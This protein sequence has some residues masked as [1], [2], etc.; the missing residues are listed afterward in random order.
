MG[1]LVKLLIFL[2]V[3]AIAISVVIWVRRE[4]KR[5]DLEGRLSSWAGNCRQVDP[6]ETLFVLVT[7]SHS[8]PSSELLPTLESLF[9]QAFCPQRVFVGIVTA[10]GSADKQLLLFPGGESDRESYPY[11]SRFARHVRMTGAASDEGAAVARDLGVRTLLLDERYLLLVHSH[12]KF[13]PGWD[14][15]LV[16]DHG[17]KAK[18]V[19][20]QRGDMRGVAQFSRILDV[21]SDGMPMLGSRDFRSQSSVPRETLF[22]TSRCLFGLAEDLRVP[23]LLGDA[24]LLFA[25]PHVDDFWLTL[26]L[27][28]A[29]VRLLAPTRPTVEHCK[30]SFP[31]QRHPWLPRLAVLH[32]HAGLALLFAEEWF[33][34]MLHKRHNHN[35]AT[36]MQ[37]L[38]HFQALPWVSV[39][40]GRSIVP[41]ALLRAM[42]FVASGGE[43]K[44]N[45]VLRAAGAQSVA[46][47]RAHD[48]IVEP[49]RQ[50]LLQSIHAGKAG[51]APGS[52]AWE[53]AVGCA[54]EAGRQTLEGIAVPGVRK[55]LERM[56]M[57]PRNASMEWSGAMG[58]AGGV[59]VP[60]AEV[61]ARFGSRTAYDLERSK[62]NQQ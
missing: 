11:A 32:V 46:L 18:T 23:S 19:L 44:V 42:R 50:Q 14:R 40:V 56:G 58:V 57:D 1:W 30:P 28:L 25:R 29:G 54:M 7:C 43:S 4:Q 61:T 5:R 48:K 55:V 47:R 34:D 49:L 15:V 22:A 2:V 10:E 60:P 20:T 24:K 6:A 52:R 21:D 35:P 53:V 38:G 8:S 37:L 51:G 33:A 26:K 62:W 39:A 27:R 16:E 17:G 12:S 41:P 13:C 31:P 59:E 45:T 3:A 36:R 9:S